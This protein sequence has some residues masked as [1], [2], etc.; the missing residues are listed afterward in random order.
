MSLFLTVA[1]AD[2]KSNL[3]VPL[4]G[5][6]LPKWCHVLTDTDNQFLMRKYKHNFFYINKS[7]AGS[8]RSHVSIKNK[9]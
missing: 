6:Y 7:T 5:Q 3:D 2:S 1:I 8:P 9:P 4:K